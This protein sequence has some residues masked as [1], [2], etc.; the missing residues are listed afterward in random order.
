MGLFY[1]DSSQKVK[2]IYW[3]GDD[4]VGY[5]TIAIEHDGRIWIS[6]NREIITLQLMKGY[7]PA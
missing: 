5:K 2:A 6:Q 1:K 3:L 4:R 7:T